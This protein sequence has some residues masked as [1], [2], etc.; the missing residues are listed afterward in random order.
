MNDNDNVLKF[1]GGKGSKPALSREEATKIM[2]D[3]E[4]KAKEAQLRVLDSVRALVES[5]VITS[6]A[7]IGR[8]QNG[9]ILTEFCPPGTHSYDYPAVFLGALH[10]LEAE[11]VDMV[12]AM[13]QMLNDGT[14]V[15]H[16]DL[17]V[18]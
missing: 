5:G 15:A 12:Q 3:S 14:I 18:L 16:S 8:A 6:F 1:P 7:L 11:L 17:T 9:A 2:D 4:A 13:P 10:G